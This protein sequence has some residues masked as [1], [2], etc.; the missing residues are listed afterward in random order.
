MRAAAPELGCGRRRGNQCRA[1]AK[2]SPR[3]GGL[4][5]KFAF[6]NTRHQQ[7]PPIVN[8][9]AGTRAPPRELAPNQAAARSEGLQELDEGAFVDIA[10]R[11]GSRA[12]AR[13]KIVPAVNHEIRAL[14]ERQQGLHKVSEDFARF[15]IVRARRQLLQVMRK[16]DQ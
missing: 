13:A 2:L 3:Q 11:L 12:L 6:Q 15:D 1:A 8:V 16:P 14:A 4:N 9:L 10:E 7:W 5:A